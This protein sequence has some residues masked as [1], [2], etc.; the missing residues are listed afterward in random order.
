M[1]AVA[2]FS[3]ACGSLYSKHNELPASSMLSMS[4]QC[5]A[6][7]VALWVGGFLTGEVRHFHFSAV[8]TRSWL[9]VAYLIVFGSGIGFTAYIYI[10]KNST[11]ARVATYAFVNPVVALLLGWL[12]AA[13]VLTLRTLLA[14]IVI[15]GAVI[16][17]ITAPHRL[18]EKRV[19]VSP[20]PSASEA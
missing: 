4:M 1:L 10:L 8:S 16:L 5:L 7:G 18:P 3:W 12:F 15:L 20:L 13:E 6:G 9:A 2:S 19:E 11:A 17:V 14:A